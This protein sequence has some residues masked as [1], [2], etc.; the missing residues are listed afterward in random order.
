MLILLVDKLRVFP[1]P[2]WLKLSSMLIG[3]I[4]TNHIGSFQIPLSHRMFYVWDFLGGISAQKVM[5][6]MDWLLSTLSW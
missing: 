2:D 1:I 6:N 4:P 3:Q 5:L